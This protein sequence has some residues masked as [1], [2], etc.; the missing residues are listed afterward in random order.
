MKKR[1]AILL[2]AVLFVGSALQAQDTA[3]SVLRTWKD[4]TGQFSFQAT[5]VRVN[6]DLV[7]SVAE[8][9][10]TNAGPVI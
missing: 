9:E 2:L 1:L 5:F 10:T 8:G 6:G 7:L 4:S 3:K